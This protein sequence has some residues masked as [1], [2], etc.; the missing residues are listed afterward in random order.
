MVCPPP[1]PMHPTRRPPELLALFFINYPDSGFYSN[2]R[3]KHLQERGPLYPPPQSCMSLISAV[4]HINSLPL[5]HSPEPVAVLPAPGP[6]G[7]RLGAL[8]M[9]SCLQDGTR[10][11]LVMMSRGPQ[12]GSPEVRTPLPEDGTLS[13]LPAS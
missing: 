8:L 10:E 2:K 3:G 1:V 7:R 9:M 6:A 13:S 5:P 11:Q 4:P 12:K